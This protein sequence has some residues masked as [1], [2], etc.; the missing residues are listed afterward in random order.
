MRDAARET[1]L[2]GS[3]DVVVDN[4]VDI[5][6]DV[7]LGHDILARN[8]GDLNFDVDDAKLLGP[9]VDCDAEGRSAAILARDANQL[10]LDETGV[11]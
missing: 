1:N 2:E 4:T 5:H 9:R 10:T 7:V 6:G 11:H 8:V 3:D